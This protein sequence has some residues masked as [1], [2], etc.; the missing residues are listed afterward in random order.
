MTIDLTGLPPKPEEVEAFLKDESADA[1][2]KLVDRLLDSPAL[3]RDAGPATGSTSPATPRTRPTRSRVKPY[4]EAWRYRDWVIRAFNEDLPFDEFVKYQIAADLIL[5]DSP[6]ELRHRAALG[7][8]GL[9]AQYYKNSDK[10]KAEADE[11]DDRVDTLTRG[12]LGLTV[13]CARCHDHK[14]DPI[15]QQDYY[16]LAGVF[17]STKLAD[18]P[19]APKAEVERVTAALKKVADAAKAVKDFLQ[20][21]KAKLEAAK[22]DDLPKYVLAAWKLEAKRLEK[23]D[24]PAAAV[25]KADAA[26]RADARPDDAATSAG[27]TSPPR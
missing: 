21:E 1:Y 3:R 22:A 16:S 11:L 19:L 26:R 2:A 9:G 4:S 7:F 8:F 18:V 25:A 20:A 23:P 6:D 14:F 24:A 27:R 10:A 13:S 12:F 15:P 5:G 17:W